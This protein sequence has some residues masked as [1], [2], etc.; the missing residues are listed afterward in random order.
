MIRSSWLKFLI[1][2]MGWKTLAFD[3][4]SLLSPVLQSK[5]PSFLF[6]DLFLVLHP[7]EVH[8]HCL[9][10]LCWFPQSYSVYLDSTNELRL[11]ESNGKEGEKGE[12]Q[13]FSGAAMGRNSQSQPDAIKAKD[14]AIK[15]IINI[16]LLQTV[17]L[18]LSLWSHLK[19]SF[20]LSW[21]Y[22]KADFR[23]GKWRRKELI[24]G[25]KIGFR[26]EL[27]KFLLI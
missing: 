3:P 10:S 16:M 1:S 8:P 18:L 24:L 17:C 21:P 15:T 26:M 22:Q 23:K 6:L 14:C 12:K 20:L 27:W 2:T 11:G 25:I 5:C 9:A 13:G 4:W 19:A 7:S